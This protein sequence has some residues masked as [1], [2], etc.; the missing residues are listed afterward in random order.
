MTKNNVHISVVIPVYG[1][2]LS[3]NELYNRLNK[4]LNKITL[5]FEIIFVNDA[6]PENDWE[7]ITKLSKKDDRIK[8]INLSRNFGQH[9]AITAGIDYCKGDWVIIMDGDLQDQPE[10]IPNFYN[11]A[12][13]GYDIVLGRREH[14]Q[15]SFLKKIIN[16]IF[17]NLFYYLTNTKID[18]SVANYRIVSRKVIDNYIKLKEYHRF[19]NLSMAWLGFNFTYINIEH[20]KRQ[21]GKSSYS[22][23]KLFNLAINAI[24]SFSDKPLRLTIK[25]GFTLIFISTIFFIYKI[26]E[27]IIYGT[28]ATGWSSI[29]ASIFFSTGIIISVLGIIGLYIGRIFE[30]VKQRPLYVISEKINIKK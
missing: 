20:S 13:E 4:S 18:N 30:E 25:L 7:I 27:N 19:L 1:C 12:Q 2:S 14:R 3:L 15:D 10:E 23:N 6:S 22:L 11:K 5:D 29:I 24:I 26:S 8:G 21:Y 16:K 9:Y 17:Y 28:T